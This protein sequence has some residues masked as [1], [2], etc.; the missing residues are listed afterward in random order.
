MKLL[1]P[2]RRDTR[3]NQAFTAVVNLARGT[4]T[5]RARRTRADNKENREEGLP[6]KQRADK[7]EEEE[8]R[9]QH[10]LTLAAGRR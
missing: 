3:S 1:H 8:Y 4:K 2:P 6:L 7:I 9:R 10:A 5:T